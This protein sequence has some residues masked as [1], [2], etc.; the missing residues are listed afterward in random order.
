MVSCGGLEGGSESEGDALIGDIG[1]VGSKGVV[2]VVCALSRSRNSKQ[3]RLDSGRT[4]AGDALG[5]VGPVPAVLNPG[6][7]LIDDCFA[8]KR[9]ELSRSCS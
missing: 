1:G 3:E 8:A 4:S 2:V 9:P 5:S 6:V 7:I